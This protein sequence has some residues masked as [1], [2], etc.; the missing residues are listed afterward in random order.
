MSRAA[1]PRLKQGEGKE[2]EQ[3]GVQCARVEISKLIFPFLELLLVLVTMPMRTLFLF[4]YLCFAASPFLFGRCLWIGSKFPA[5]L[6]D[7]ALPQF[8]EATVRGLQQ[9]EQENFIFKS[10]QTVL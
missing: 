6:P 5:H 9:G 1:F 4:Y 10:H 2:F 8:L 7:E 3:R